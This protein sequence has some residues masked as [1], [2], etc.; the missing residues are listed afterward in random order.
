MGL[1]NESD[2]QAEW[3]GV[4]DSDHL[5]LDGLKWIWYPE[6]NPAQGAPEAERYFRKTFHLPE[7]REIT[8]GRLLLTADDG[9]VLYVNGE[10]VASSPRVKL[11][12]RSD[13]C[14]RGECTKTR[15]QRFRH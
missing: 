10:R 7:D 3:I 15:R 2:W 11:L 1:L 12:E 14:R 6:G 13:A 4:S 9:F 5:T 8:A